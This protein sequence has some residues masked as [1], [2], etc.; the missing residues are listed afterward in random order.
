MIRNNQNNNEEN[1][2]WIAYADLMA[3]LLFVFILLIGA[4]VVKYVLTQSDLKIIKENL[5]KQEQ[6]LRENKEELSQKEDIL[7][8]LNQKLNNTSNTLNDINKQKQELEANVN[9]YVR[10]NQ[11]LN[12]SIDEKDQQ[13]FTLLERLNKKDEQIRDLEANFDEAKIKIKE[14]SLIK[15]N[16][17][18]NLQSKID[19]N[20]TLDINS[21]A[22]ILP[23][24][25]LFDSNS[26]TLKAQAKENLKTILTQYFDGILKDEKILSSIE[27]IVIEGHT[28]SAGSYIYNLDLSQKRAY[29]VMSF[30]YS[31]YKDPRLQK[32]LMA[33]GRSYSDVVMKDGKEDQ[34]ASRRIEIKFNINTNNALEKVEKYLDSK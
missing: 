30:I 16:T 34:Q 25:V 11:D 24:E 13:I 31:F 2:F 15:E 22:I 32:L 33:S 19:D 28:D 9:S 29:A 5:E 7:K 10:L 1:N 14:L 26:F 18:K 21:G 4:I 20:I 12:S 27:N 8:N 17:I 3:G 6:R 23:S